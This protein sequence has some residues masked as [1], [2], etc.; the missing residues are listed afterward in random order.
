MNIRHEA[1]KRALGILV[2]IELAG[3]RPDIIPLPVYADEQTYDFLLPTSDWTFNRWSD[4]NNEVARQLQGKGYKVQRVTIE[5]QEYINFLA[6]HQ[7][8]NSTANREQFVAW[9][10][11]PDDAKPTLHPD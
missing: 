1:K 11:A 3:K 8:K 9:K 10:I 6:T 4:V 5:L 2:K 7:L